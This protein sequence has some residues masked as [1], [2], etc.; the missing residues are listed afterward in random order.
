MSDAH[1]I[2]L[3][4]LPPAGIIGL[5]GAPDDAGFL[6]AVQAALGLALPTGPCT[7][8]NTAAVQALWLAPDEWLL[9]C[10]RAA[11]A[12]L[13][14]QL[15]EALRTQHHQC[16]DNSGGFA[17]FAVCGDAAAQVLAHCSVYDCA[18]LA[19]GR[20]VGTTLGRV[21]AFIRRDAATG[22]FVLLVRS[23]FADHA[24]R[25]LQR[26][27]LPYASAAPPAL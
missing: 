27:A 17:Q 20:V 10:E 22:G 25:I 14:A 13:L 2:G 9:L 4:A 1:R 24:W 3:H 15:R 16:V 8:A 5:R 23:S 7:S 26:A 11:V 12:P 21:T 6:A 18:R 19:P